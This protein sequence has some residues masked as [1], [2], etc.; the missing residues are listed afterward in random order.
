MKQAE[1]A[2]SKP[3]LLEIRRRNRLDVRLRL[4]LVGALAAWL[5]FGAIG[6]FIVIRNAETIS[7][8]GRQGEA[9]RSA[10]RTVA[11]FLDQAKDS[12]ITL[13]LVGIDEVSNAPKTTE[14]MM[15]QNVALQEILVVD[16]KGTILTGTSKDRP[17]LS[18][19]GNNSAVTMV[20]GRSRR[21]TVCGQCPDFSHE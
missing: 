9:A 10:A 16:S 4:L 14:R 6:G 15:A 18:K 11:N 2:S 20:P 12:M 8:R 21:T 1:P 7:W 19:S 13:G 17:V 5:S 3:D